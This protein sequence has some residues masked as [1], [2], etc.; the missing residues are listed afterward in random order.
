MKGLSYDFAYW[1]RNISNSIK[2]DQLQI[3]EFFNSF[4]FWFRDLF[5]D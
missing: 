3:V 5:V 4:I 2:Q 1:S